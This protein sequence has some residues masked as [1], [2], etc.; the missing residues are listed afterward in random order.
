MFLTTRSREDKSK[1]LRFFTGFCFWSDR[2]I[3]DAK[4]DGGSV[5]TTETVR[6][7]PINQMG[8]S[9]TLVI[10]GAAASFAE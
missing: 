10:Y 2:S 6:N 3:T 9:V 5:L 1:V 8:F 7:V 4:R